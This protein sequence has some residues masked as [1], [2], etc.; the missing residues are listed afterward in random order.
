M[1]ALRDRQ[2]KLHGARAGIQYQRKID[3]M[4]VNMEK[5]RAKQT[6][7]LPAITSTSKTLKINPKTAI[8][9]YAG[10]KQSTYSSIAPL[11][12]PQQSQSIV[13]NSATI[14]NSSR[15]IMMPTSAVDNKM[16]SPL[17]LSATK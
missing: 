7:E 9:D 2:I 15:S 11:I 4:K 5:M 8:L 12:A 6:A 1:E 14:S 16:R 10:K 17:F 13:S 3:E